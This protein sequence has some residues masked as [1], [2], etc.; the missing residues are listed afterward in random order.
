MAQT[1]EKAVK[2]KVVAIIKEYDAYY[3]YPISGGYGASGVPDIVCCYRG[4]FI[5]FECKAGKN[6]VTALQGK[7]IQHIRDNGGIARIINED[8]IE[9]VRRIFEQFL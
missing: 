4:M 3:F 5:A 1:P 9:E 6:T 7:N 2:R 8:N